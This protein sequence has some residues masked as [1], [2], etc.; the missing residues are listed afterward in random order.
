MVCF[1]FMYLQKLKE[2]KQTKDKNIEKE[3][4][5]SK[6]TFKKK[7]LEKCDISAMNNLNFK[8]FLIITGIHSLNQGCVFDSKYLDC[9]L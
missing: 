6:T 4:E 5:N 2:K 9:L 1:M 3:I 8:T 7:I